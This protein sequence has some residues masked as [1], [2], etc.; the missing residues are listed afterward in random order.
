MP[1]KLCKYTLP[2]GLTVR[3]ERTKEAQEAPRQLSAG[4][5]PESGPQIQLTQG[6]PE[7]AVAMGKAT[8]GIATV[9]SVSSKNQDHQESRDGKGHSGYCDF[10]IPSALRF[11]LQVAMGK[12]TLGIATSQQ[13]ARLALPAP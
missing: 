13:A 4:P 12:A 5:P 2:K 6:L 11:L 10:S 1:R 8:L 3:T 7:G 9:V